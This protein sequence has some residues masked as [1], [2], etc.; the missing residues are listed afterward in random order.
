MGGYY[1]KVYALYDSLRQSQDSFAKEF[2]AG[3]SADR[4]AL[5]TWK[6][7]ENIK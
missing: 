7:L 6:M 2:S 1:N 4:L 5:K 3:A